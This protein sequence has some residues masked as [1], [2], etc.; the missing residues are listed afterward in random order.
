LNI[1]G[2]GTGPLHKRIRTQMKVRCII[3]PEV[4]SKPDD[5]MLYFGNLV[6]GKI[7][8][9]KSIENDWYRIIDNSNEDYL[10][11]PEL[12]EIVDKLDF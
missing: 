1:K 9:V 7:Y 12:F 3:E 10:Y 4:N 2:H 8:D 6:Y 5:F 11:P